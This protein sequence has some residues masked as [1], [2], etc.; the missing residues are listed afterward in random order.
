MKKL[1]LV[2]LI[3]VFAFWSCRPEVNSVVKFSSAD[4]FSPGIAKTGDT[5]D[6]L[7]GSLKGSKV[8]L[9]DIEVP[10]LSSSDG[11]L[12]FVVTDNLTK[13]NPK[14]VFELSVKFKDGS[15]TK[16]SQ[17]IVLNYIY[18][19][20]DKVTWLKNYVVKDA[21]NDTLSKGPAQLLISDFD[22]HGARAANATNRFDQTQWTSLVKQGGSSL[23][24]SNVLGVASSKAKGNYFALQLNPEFV[25]NGT[26]GFVGEFISATEVS[27]NRDEAWAINFSALPG[28]K[29]RIPT[30]NRRKINTISMDDTYLNFYVFKNNKE[31]TL[32][33]TYITSDLLAGSTQFAYNPQPSDGLSEWKLM[34]IPFRSFRTG[35]GFDSKA[36]EVVDYPT[37]NKLNFTFTHADK[38]A[39]TPSNPSA[40][41][42][43]ATGEVQIYLD[44]III[45]QGGPYLEPPTK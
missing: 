34:S 1:T 32:L 8:F 15:S 3:F 24:G 14:G 22:G 7:G 12:Q 23:I 35:Y 9:D 45:T 19:L 26:S 5:V 2:S 27:N 41:V 18:T 11:L 21:I 44:H 17:N 10:L 13:S 39:E 4:S 36:I 43:P 20:T 37:L 29:I 42:N 6:I 40:W 25:E 38:A 16:F 30:E 33:R 31:K 28:S